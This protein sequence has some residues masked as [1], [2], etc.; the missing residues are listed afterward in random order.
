MLLACPLWSRCR[1]HSV[2]FY[3]RAAYH[4]VFYW[5]PRLLRPVRCGKVP[6]GFYWGSVWLLRSIVSALAWPVCDDSPASCPFGFIHQSE[7]TT[8]QRVA[9]SQQHTEAP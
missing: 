2:V 6:P 7:Q 4:L 9:C 3:S 1:L 8:G 5:E